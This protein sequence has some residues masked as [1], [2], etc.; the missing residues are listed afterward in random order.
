MDLTCDCRAPPPAAGRTSSLALQFKAKSAAVSAR[1]ARALVTGD[2]K[3]FAYKE[4]GGLPRCRRHRGRRDDRP[5]GRHR[6]RPPPPP[7]R[8]DWTR[9]V[10]PP[11]L[12]GHVSSLLIRVRARARAHPVRLERSC[13]A[14]GPFAHWACPRARARRYGRGTRREKAMQVCRLSRPF[15]LRPSGARRP[16]AAR[17]SRAARA[18]AG[19]GA[20]G[21]G[22]R[23][24]GGA[25]RRGV[26][27]GRRGHRRDQV[28]HN[29]SCS[30]WKVCKVQ[31][32]PGVSGLPGS[33]PNT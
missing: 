17:G 11:V 5:R 2:L 27:A 8:T 13:G 4:D 29:L 26:V 7:S 14:W 19:G 9:L 30:S 3:E 21:R 12:T 20:S 24:A 22:A 28:P 15:P 1:G 10:P 32:L 6:V 18:Q 33:R 16:R 25:G 31:T 23:G